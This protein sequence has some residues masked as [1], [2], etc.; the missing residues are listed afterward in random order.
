MVLNKVN[1]KRY[2]GQAVNLNKRWNFEHKVNRKSNIILQK[3]IKKYGIKNF[4]FIVLEYLPPIKKILTN[5]EQKWLDYFKDNDKWDML[6]N[7]CPNAETALGLKR[8][9]RECD[10]IRE[11]TSIPVYQYDL[12]GNFIKEY[13]SAV[14]AQKETGISSGHISN[15][16]VKSRRSAGKFLWLASQ[17]NE[18]IKEAIKIYNSAIIR[19]DSRKVI[20][21]NENN[22]E[23]MRF[24]SIRE[25]ELH[26]KLKDSKGK[27][28]M[29]SDG[30]RK[31][32]YGYKWQYA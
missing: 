29:V 23:L 24:N 7:I 28:A 22:D 16:R 2:I 10:I 19:S 17:N 14:E 30:K 20:M 32:A 8:T 21:L 15:C 27:I 1:N 18:E 5:T 26:L 6:Y 31:T 11:R 13:S 12:E 4:E 3:A 25:A 9:Q